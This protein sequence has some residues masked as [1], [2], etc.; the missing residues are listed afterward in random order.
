LPLRGPVMPSAIITRGDGQVKVMLDGRLLSCDTSAGSSDAEASPG[1]LTPSV[2][3]DCLNIDVGEVE[4]VNTFLHIGGQ[5]LPESRFSSAPGGLDEDLLQAMADEKRAVLVSWADASEDDIDQDLLGRA[6]SS[7]VEHLREEASCSMSLSTLGN[8]LPKALH[9]ELRA[10]GIKVAALLRCIPGVSV[11]GTTVTME[12]LVPAT[13]PEPVLVR[14]GFVKAMRRGALGLE[15]A[16]QVLAVLDAILSLLL[17]APNQEQSTFIMGNAL[18]AASRAFLK[19]HAVRLVMLVRQFPDVF[20]CDR[21]T[22]KR[23]MVGL[24]P[25]GELVRERVL[26]QLCC[27]EW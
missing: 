10:R 2:R 11:V 1:S 26:E 25:N 17:E 12:G 21:G 19:H 5:R 13:K 18:P 6:R 3:S 9:E 22:D 15:E 16:E 20:D 24:V 14:G 27:G 23:P 8:R 4:V 7:V